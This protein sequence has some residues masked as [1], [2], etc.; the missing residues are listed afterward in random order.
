LRRIVFW[1]NCQMQVM[2]S[3]HSRFVKPLTDETST[4]VDAFL[5]V[6]DSDRAA[7]AAADLI[8]GQIN[9][10][11]RASLE[12]LAAVASPAPRH[13]VPTVGAPFLWPFAG[14]AHP[15]YLH[16]SR[17]P[18][19]M[20]DG[21]LNR[22]I[23]QN[24]PAAEAARRY[25]EL[26][27]NSV[28][29]LDR[30]L[31]VNIDQQRMRDELTD[32]RFADLILDRF[33][34]EYLFLENYHP[35]VSFVRLWA[36][37]IFRRIGTSKTAIE[38]IEQRLIFTPFPETALPIHPSVIR[39]FGLT[40]LTPE[41][42]YR[43]TSESSVTFNHFI[44][45][46]LRFEWNEDLDKGVALMR[47]GQREAAVVKLQQGVKRTPDSLDGIRW[48]TKALAQLKRHNE[49]VIIV[50]Q[51]IANDANEAVLHEWLAELLQGNGRLDEAETACR[52]AVAL[53]P[54]IGSSHARLSHVLV[55]QGH[56]PEALEEVTTATLLDGYQTSGLDLGILL[57]RLGRLDEA[58][59]VLRLTIASGSRNHFV[60]SHLSRVLLRQGKIDAAID[61]ARVVLD[62]MP[63]HVPGYS[64]LS[65]VL[66]EAGQ[67]EGAEA[68]LRR[69]IDALP[70]ALHLY[71]NL[72]LLLERRG[73]MD[74]AIAAV[75]RA[76]G[77]AMGDV[78][79]RL[80][81]SKLLDGAGQTDEAEATLRD[82]IAVAPQNARFHNGL[83]E[84]LER[85]GRPDAAIETATRAV[86]IGALDAHGYL[87]LNDLLMRADRPVEAEA[88]IR[89]A[90]EIS[91]NNPRL[92]HCMSF[93]LQR[94]GDMDGALKSVLRALELNRDNAQFHFRHSQLLALRGEIE[95][96]F[97]AVRR[98]VA[99]NPSEA[100][101]HAHLGNLF[102]HT[103]QFDEAEAAY[104]QALAFARDGKGIREALERV[105]TTRARLPKP[106]VASDPIPTLAHAGP[107]VTAMM[108][109]ISEAHPAE[110][111]PAAPIAQSSSS[112]EASSRMMTRLFDQ[113]RHVK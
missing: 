8:V 47:A 16:F 42:R 108:G 44:M 31:E 107:Q 11:P 91:P 79:A 96:A 4:F 69:G 36:T 43:C 51:A 60:H 32:Y 33:R 65:A 88:A 110:P 82:A 86:E 87:R 72:S 35:N 41:S 58:E 77:S 97:E 7:M 112:F 84:L 3:L 100:T 37:E 75:R 113:V 101:S 19:N 95:P 17:F 49:A 38:R 53:S 63:T 71:N 54:N 9:L 85:H 55:A 57:A 89:Q 80:R 81:L 50:R 24:I 20:G 94:K 30:L 1:G 73:R 45:R 67:I 111:D 106:P 14:Q 92:H 66:E 109:Q 99:L 5:P 103:K 70:Q 83:V 25:L 62:L 59:A 15:K 21:F 76:V 46:Y 12:A 28:V 105:R 27:I 98:S 90:I 6:S 13:L 74:E 68:T 56:L 64:V 61:A 48:L 102:A 29:D 78:D 18:P 23:K 52:R 10:N 26:D 40:F 22:M 93:L 2:H 39:H 104:V 34:N